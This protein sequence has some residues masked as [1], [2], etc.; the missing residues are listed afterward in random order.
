DSYKSNLAKARVVSISNAHVINDV[1]NGDVIV[2]DMNDVVNGSAI[3]LFVNYMF[4]II[5]SIDFLLLH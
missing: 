4:L 5:T 3:R 2:H 1:V